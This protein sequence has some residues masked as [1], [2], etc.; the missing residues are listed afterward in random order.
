[1]ILEKN[2]KININKE[3]Y[4]LYDGHQFQCYVWREGGEL[5]RNPANGEMIESKGKWVHT[6][7]YLTNL[8]SAVQELAKY[9]A[10]QQ[11]EYTSLGEFVS[12]Y[13]AAYSFLRKALEI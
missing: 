11:D 3:S 2:T 4:I 8:E 5:V 6:G 7:T 10:I 9:K 13:K 1:M 12:E